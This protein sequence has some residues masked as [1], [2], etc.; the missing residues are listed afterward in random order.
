KKRCHIL[1]GLVIACNNIDEVIKIIRKAE[2]TATAKANL[3]KKFNLSDEQAQAILDMKLYRINK[4]EVY[5]LQAELE[6]LKAKIQ[7]LSEIVAKKDLQ[8]KVVKKELLEVKKLFKNDRRTQIVGLKEKIKTKI[9][10]EA[11]E[12]DNFVV[13]LTALGNVK[14]I[15]ERQYNNAKKI[16]TDS[17]SLSEVFTQ[18]VRAQSGDTVLAFTNLGN[19]Y[20]I[21]VDSLPDAKYKEKGTAFKALVKPEGGEKAVALFAVGD[22][23]PRGNL[24]F[25]TRLGQVKASTWAEYDV[26]K[27]SF[28]AIKLKEGDSVISI[29]EDKPD[30]TMLFVTARGMALNATKDDLPL[31][32]RIATG[33]GGVML[34]RGDMV[35]YAGQI[36][37][38]GEIVVV[39]T[40]GTFKRVIAADLDPLSRRRKGVIISDLSD[41][42]EILFISYVTH[43]YDVVVEDMTGEIFAVNTEDISIE[44]R[45]SKGK[46]LKNVRGLDIKDCYRPQKAEK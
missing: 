39:T 43:A 31:Q 9:E 26:Q 20:K 45:T 2:D 34:D 32:G 10:E 15:P 1:E 37:D 5:T 41:E 35:V 13:A 16:I 36:K 40:E 4:M 14:K 11:P 30:T 12:K 6:D 8:M 22:K 23:M 21:E 38:E 44:K 42:N 28:Q 27:A 24:L 25:F 19:C 29:E 17:S 18:A 7:E 33:V 3:K 46:T